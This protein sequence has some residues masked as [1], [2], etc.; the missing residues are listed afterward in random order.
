MALTFGFYNSVGDDRLYDARQLSSIFK[1]IISEGVFKSLGTKMAVTPSSGM[2]VLVGAGRAW[3]LDT[4]TDIDVPISVTIGAASTPLNRIDA[5]CL[6]VDTRVAVRANKLVVVP[7][8]PATTPVKPGLI[9]DADRKQ[10]PIAY[11]TVPT[12]ATSIT[13]GNIENRGGLFDF[14]YITTLDSA[15]EIG[16]RVYGT[17]NY[18]ADA[19]TITES[20]S[21]I[22]NLVYN[23]IS[24]L[25]STK[26]NN[27]SG[28]ASTIVSAGLLANRVLISDANGKVAASPNVTP[29][30]LGFLSGVTSAIQTQINNALTA[31]SVTANRAL[32][33]NGSGNVAA[34]PVTA[35]ELGFLSGVRSA[36]QAQIDLIEGSTSALTA[37]KV[38]ISNASGGITTAAV[39]TTEL[40][41]LAGVTAAIQTQLNAKQAT[42]TGSGSSIMS[43]SLAASRALITDG[44][45]KVAASA[46]TSTELGYLA[47]VTG[48]VQTQ[49]NGKLGSTAQAADS[50]KVGGKKITVGTSAPASPS[51]GDVWI[52]T[53]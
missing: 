21:A 27:I 37:N 35:T 25:M 22:D 6:E 43:A 8:T 29:T 26:Q 23:A 32:I 36:I 44:S 3:F 48:A 16:D 17:H 41:Y 7:G 39:N 45:S 18:I 31:I 47:G 19:Q 46:V 49:L 11:V 40:G 51:V 33:S 30:E 24:N 15:N 14:P 5:I 4:W 12:G 38:L 2:N 50:V 34:S 9:N 13:V 42:A 28:A 20:L 53:N 52:D 1:G 10:Y